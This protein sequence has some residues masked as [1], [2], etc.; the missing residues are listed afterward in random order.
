MADQ[1]PSQNGHEPLLDL[2]EITKNRPFIRDQESKPHF[3]KTDGLGAVDHHRL[4]HL[5][6]RDD[7]FVQR[8]PDGLTA[9]EKKQE[10]EGL[11]E[12][13][14]IVLDAPARVR[15]QIKGQHARRLVRHFQRASDPDIGAREQAEA[16]MMLMAQMLQ[17]QEPES[18]A[19]ESPSTTAT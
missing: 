4:I 6:R 17:G 7:E 16:A 9:E 11:D 8:D 5:L 13:L 14:S 12:M 10:T 18:E 1:T 3:L 15:K 19:D 2:S